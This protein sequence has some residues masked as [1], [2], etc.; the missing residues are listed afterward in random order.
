M[1]MFLMALCLSMFGL[2]VTA[3]AFG[4]ATRDERPREAAQ[5]E[6]QPVLALPM[7]APRFFVDTG[8]PIPS[9]RPSPV[10]P[11]VPIEVLL[12][13]IERHVRLEQAAAESFLDSPTSE[14]L[15]SRTTSP[16]V[17]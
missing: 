9:Q 16:L 5:P 2:A 14:S 1:V 13:Q 15:H 8:K 3:L 17:H 7:D 11:R 10:I 12:M 4:A 6:L